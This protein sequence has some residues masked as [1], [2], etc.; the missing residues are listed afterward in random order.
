MADLPESGSES[1]DSEERLARGLTPTALGLGD[2]V[3]LYLQ[4]M[5]AIT[6]MMVILSII[7][8]PLMILYARNTE[9]NVYSLSTLFKYFTLGNLG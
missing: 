1:C 3:T 8:I 6:V 2:G 7:N 5:K 4:M 9:G